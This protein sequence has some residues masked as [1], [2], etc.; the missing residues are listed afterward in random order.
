MYA[1]RSCV[2]KKKPYGA[3][4]ITHELHDQQL[5]K[6]LI[7]EQILL[8]STLGNVLGTVWRIYIMSRCQG[9]T[10]LLSCT[11]N[12]P[13]LWRVVE[14][15][16]CHGTVHLVQTFG[17]LTSVSA[18]QIHLFLI[19]K[20]IQNPYFLDNFK[21]QLSQSAVQGNWPGAMVVQTKGQYFPEQLYQVRLVTSSLL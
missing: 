8:V 5:K 15:V 7:G 17:T 21:Q 3:P 6:L 16:Y 14:V 10:V 9:L 4:L 13:F 19:K 12:Q 18:H 20:V 11:Y 2:A 1:P